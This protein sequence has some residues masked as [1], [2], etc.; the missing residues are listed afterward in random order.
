MDEDRIHGRIEQLVAEEHEL[1]QREAADGVTDDDRRRLDELKVLLDQ[2][3]DL[4][5]QRRALHEAGFDE[6]AARVRDPEVVERY[7]Q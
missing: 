7:Q 6:D 3:W 4:L 5:R 1:W 2:C